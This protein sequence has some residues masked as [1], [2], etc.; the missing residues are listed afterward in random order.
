LQLTPGQ[1]LDAAT[2][3][4]SAVVLMGSININIEVDSARGN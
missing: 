2:N 4:P 3:K 1:P